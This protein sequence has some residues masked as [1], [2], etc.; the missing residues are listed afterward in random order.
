MK[1]RRKG[2]SDLSSYGEKISYLY[3]QMLLHLLRR[4]EN[5]QVVVVLVLVLQLEEECQ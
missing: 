2:L 3:Q 1:R 4:E 5:K